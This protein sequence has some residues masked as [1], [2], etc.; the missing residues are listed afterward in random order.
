MILVRPIFDT[1]KHMRGVIA[2][3]LPLSHAGEGHLIFA[4]MGEEPISGHFRF[5]EAAF[6]I[7]LRRAHR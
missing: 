4:R 7:S 5:P 3:A 2:E 1:V 6:K